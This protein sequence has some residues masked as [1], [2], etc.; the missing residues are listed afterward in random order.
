MVTATLCNPPYFNLKPSTGLRKRARDAVSSNFETDFQSTSSMEPVDSQT[1]DNWWCTEHEI[2][3]FLWQK[4]HNDLQD[5]DVCV[6][7]KL[8]K[9]VSVIT[10]VIIPTFK[11]TVQTRY[12]KCFMYTWDMFESDLAD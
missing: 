6:L 7:L 10:I 8:P 12:L 3:S 5:V 9:S 1:C 11:V 4:P 2:N